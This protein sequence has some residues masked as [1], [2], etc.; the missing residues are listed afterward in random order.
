MPESIPTEAQVDAQYVLF[1]GALPV[2]KAAHA[3]RWIVWLDRLQG[4]FDTEH[5]A[6]AWALKHLGPSAAFV[7]ARAE[8]PKPTA[9][10]G[11]SMFELPR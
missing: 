8:D 10:S 3:G 11:L 1:A 5:D 4:D 2:L 7:V 9:L 6:E